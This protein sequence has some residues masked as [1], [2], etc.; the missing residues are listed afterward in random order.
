MKHAND[1]KAA[2]VCTE[3]DAE[4]MQDEL[5]NIMNIG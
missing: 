4:V 3:K 5:N 2:R 1:M